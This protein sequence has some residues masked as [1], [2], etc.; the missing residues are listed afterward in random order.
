M[1]EKRYGSA[2]RDTMARLRETLDRASTARRA[3]RKRK[4]DDNGTAVPE[5]FLRYSADGRSVELYW[6]WWTAT[7][8]DG[9]GEYPGRGDVETRRAACEYGRWTE[10]YFAWYWKQL[11]CPEAGAQAATED[12]AIWWAEQ[13]GRW[14]TTG[15]P[16]AVAKP[17]AASPAKDGVT[18]QDESETDATDRVAAADAALAAPSPKATRAPERP[19]LPSVRKYW[20]Q[21]YLLFSRFDEGVRLD[22][23]GWFS[24][25][26]E[27]IAEH[28]AYR[29]QTDVIV[30]AF[31]GVGGNA[32]QFALTCHRVIAIDLDPVRLRCA[33]HNARVY[34][35]ANRIDFICGDF[36]ALAPSLKADAVFLSPPWGGPHY[37]AVEQ[38][39]LDMTTPH[40]DTI[41]AAARRISDNIALF[42]PNTVNIAQAAALAADAGL[43]CDVEA[44][45]TKGKHKTTTIYYGDF[46][47]QSGK[48]GDED[49]SA[50]A[51]SSSS[52]ASSSS[53]SAPSER[54]SK[55]SIRIA[56]ESDEA[57]DRT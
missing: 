39:D 34:G 20:Y 4:L 11:G 50:S 55:R 17:R 26:P 40:S 47:T 10:D 23:E 46:A 9:D 36:L 24:V 31:A 19:D 15:E 2:A 32:I 8:V 13:Y 49:A 14:L 25:T 56:E 16:A 6:A 12:D 45:M 1:T 37:T 5:T 51:T 21:R 54:P 57:S 42:M 28:H 27:A 33:M 43:A 35:V 41:F 53:A 44:N 48:S 30:D 18:G 22:E 29:C 7:F 38:Y 52:A 3:T